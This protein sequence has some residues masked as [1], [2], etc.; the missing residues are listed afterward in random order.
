MQTLFQDLRFAIRMLRKSG[1]STAVA[2]LS[3]ALG[4][5]ATT[6]IFSVVNA[7]LLEPFPH[8]DAWRNAHSISEYLDIR[9]QNH[10][11]ESVTAAFYQDMVLTGGAEPEPLQARFV[12]ANTFPMLDVAPLIGRAILPEDF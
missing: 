4:I 7:V 6:A 9:E 11:F 12:S 2:V 3:L 5:G 1:G 10:V 8:R